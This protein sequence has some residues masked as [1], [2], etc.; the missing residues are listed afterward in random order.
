M[1]KKAVYIE[2]A[3]AKINLFLEVFPKKD[4]SELYHEIAT[5]FQAIDLQDYLTFE[6]LMECSEEG[7][8]EEVD[9]SVSLDSNND[10]VRDLA[11]N[12]S[13]IQAIEIFFMHL[14]E[15]VVELVSRV[16]ISVYI[17][18]QIPHAAGL[19]GASA[20]AAATL[21]VLNKFIAE[22]FNCSISE[23]KLEQIALELGSD[24][25]FCLRSKQAPRLY[26]EGRGE[27][28]KT[29]PK[30]LSLTAFEAYPHLILLK[31]AFGINTPQA[32]AELS[33]QLGTQSNCSPY[34]NRF[35]TSVFKT[36]PELAHIKKTLL[37]LGCDRAMLSGSGSTMLGFLASD[38]DPAP[39]YQDLS[40]IFSDSQLYMAKML[41]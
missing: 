37:E 6:I 7:Q 8:V 18:K 14:P 13:V 23:T 16:E 27:K 40:R 33:P 19:A 34:F 21:R 32:Y 9:F 36:H 30:N 10:L 20:D 41:S 31:P 5:L 29:E 38:K 11:I 12:N 24:V 22:N 26:A 25:P 3:P 4:P 15:P 17:D 35:E 39:I 2:E 1:I 28:F